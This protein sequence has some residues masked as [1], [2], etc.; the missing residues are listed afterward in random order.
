MTK[1]KY[2]ISVVLPNYNGKQLLKSNLPSIYTALQ[3]TGLEF[4]IIVT[5]D[6]SS[7]DSVDFLS[8]E[9]PEIKIIKNETNLG[10]SSTCNIGINAASYSLLCISNTDVTFTKDYFTNAL[11]EFNDPELFAV[12][13]DILNYRDSLDN[14]T[15][16][17]TAPVL[18]YKHGFLRFD[19]NLDPGNKEMTGKLN[20][21]FVLLGCCFL[22]NTEKMRELNGF[23]TIFSPFYWEDSD[24][25]LRAIKSGYRLRYKPECRVFHRTSSTINT[26][27]KK[28]HRQLVSNRNKFLFTWRH[29]H[30]LRLWCI[31]LIFTALN[32]TTRWI[33]LDWKYYVA[34][35]WALYRSMTFATKPLP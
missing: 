21:F 5:D 3:H 26:Y 17:E 24:L 14:I 11:P 29:L 7:D 16:I 30:G 15:G 4:E 25:A 34:L 18:Y 19:H 33:I 32:L 20:E 28:Y 10:F 23:D 22:C 6:F 35:V 13:G 8:K 2:G 1:L 27:R 12:K 9:Y 31:H